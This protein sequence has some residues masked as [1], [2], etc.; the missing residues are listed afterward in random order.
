[1]EG[2]LQESEGQISRLEH[3]EK[4]LQEQDDTMY[5]LR[6]ILKWVCLLIS[7]TVCSFTDIGQGRRLLA[8]VAMVMNIF[9]MGLLSMAYTLD[10]PV[11]MRRNAVFNLYEALKYFPVDRLEIY[12]FL[13]KRLLRFL[14]L[15]GALAFPLRL[16]AEA[17]AGSLG[18][19][20]LV[21]PLVVWLMLAAAGGVM[22]RVG[23]ARRYR[24]KVRSL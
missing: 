11:A 3:F 4:M 20:S 17:L 23:M 8:T 19:S 7:V 2:K 6:R 22:I 21:A 1:M 5:L 13:R 15:Y 24:K 16:M 10:V 9:T 12:M 18:I 14:S